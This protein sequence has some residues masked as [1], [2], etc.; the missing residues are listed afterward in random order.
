M[1]R[2]NPRDKTLAQFRVPEKKNR[3]NGTMMRNIQ[4]TGPNFPEIKIRMWRYNT[5][6]GSSASSTIF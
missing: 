2:T 3:R 6:S 1:W 5:D 4:T